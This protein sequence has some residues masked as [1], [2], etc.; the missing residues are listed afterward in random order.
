MGLGVEVNIPQALK[1]F[2]VPKNDSRAMNAIGYIYFKAPDYLELD[3]AQTTK[4]GSIRKDLKKAR[5]YF[6]KAY[7]RG[8]VN[9]MYN[10]GCF[11]LQTQKSTT[12]K[13]VS[14]SFT[15]AYDYFK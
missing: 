15:D 14:F 11:H 1:H 12:L 7:Q 5:E 6:E 13:N 10:M 3:P 2:E 4:F 8:N 9:A